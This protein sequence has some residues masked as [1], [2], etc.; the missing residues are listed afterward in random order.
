MSQHNL[1]QRLDQDIKFAPSERPKRRR[2]IA[3]TH[4]PV[5]AA[6]ALTASF[7]LAALIHVSSYARLAQLEYRRQE[8]AADARLLK[9][10]NTQLRFEVERAR[11]QERVVAIAQ[12]WGMTLADPSSQVD[13]IL[14]PARARVASGAGIPEPYAVLR[15]IELARQ[16]TCLVTAGWGG[17]AWAAAGQQ[18][19]RP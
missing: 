18:V 5:I 12:Q 6:F 13:Y 16:V 7:I 3:A 2:P 8:L 14:M 19:A 4:K 11:A 17:S 1:H 9:A 15:D 10:D